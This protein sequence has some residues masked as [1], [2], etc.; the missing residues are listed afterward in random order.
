MKKKITTFS[1]LFLFAHLLFS[2][3]NN[4]ELVS[5]AGTMN[6][7][8]INLCLGQTIVVPHNGDQ[9]LD[10]DDIIR[11]VLH[12]NSGT[13]LGNITGVQLPINAALSSILSGINFGTTYYISAIAGMD[14][15]MGNVDLTD[16]ELSVA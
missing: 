10:P 16:S 11:V 2:N 13:T 7:N 1:L 5:S 3:H 15:G 8:P 6:L 9:T 4:F 12:D 14:D